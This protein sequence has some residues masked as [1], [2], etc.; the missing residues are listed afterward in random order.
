MTSTSPLTIWWLNGGTYWETNTSFSKK[1]SIHFSSIWEISSMDS[2]K[3]Q[4]RSSSFR[5]NTTNSKL[6][7]R[8]RKRKS[9][10]CMT[11]KNGI[12]VLKN[13]KLCQNSSSTTNHK[14]SKWCFL[15]KMQLW[16]KWDQICF[17]TLIN[18]FKTELWISREIVRGIAIILRSLR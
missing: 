17:C 4:Q 3:L 1:I 2:V 14:H 6:L 9:M 13:L 18:F 7:Y 5:W 10:R 11:L 15:N 16:K 12:S 8:R